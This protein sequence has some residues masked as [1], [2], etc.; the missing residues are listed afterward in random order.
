MSE[1][2]IGPIRQEELDSADLIFRRAFGTFLGVPDPSTTF[3][4]REF[5][6]GRWGNDNT[7]ALAARRGGD[8]VASNLI[9]RWGSVGWFGPLTV[10]PDLWDQGIARDLMDETARVFDRW[11]VTH[12]G[13]FT[14]GHSPKHV[15][16]YQRYGFWP[17]FLTPILS[18]PLEKGGAK[19]A[20]THSTKRFS[21][22]D[23]KGQAEALLECKE[24]T[25]GAF[26][27]L[28]LGGEI[29]SIRARSL[30]ETWLV[31]DDSRLEGFTACHIGRGSEAGTNG[32]YV[33][34]AIARPGP[35]AMG[36]FRSLLSATES[37][38]SSSGASQLE[39]GVNASHP[40]TFRLLRDRGYRVGFIGVAMHSPNEAGYHRSDVFV[41]DD[42]R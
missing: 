15:S 29:R 21:D 16:L 10:R 39:V 11:G 14:F 38:A 30:G 36:R 1:T 12:R 19:P 42:W 2:E 31:Y 24:L 6:R 33:K 32:A 40:E 22:L 9:T 35:S 18:K 5:V 27:G 34:F 37:H 17:R 26:P 20:P 25:S 41:M 7:V 8:L 28:D 13:L 4:D 3:G 23:E